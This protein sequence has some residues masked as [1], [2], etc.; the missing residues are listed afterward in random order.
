M[1]KIDIAKTDT[2]KTDTVKTDIVTRERVGLRWT[3][4]E[5]VRSRETRDEEVTR[6]EEGGGL[7]LARMARISGD[8][9]LFNIDRRLQCR[10]KEKNRTSEREQYGEPPRWRGLCTEKHQKKH[11]Q[12]TSNKSHAKVSD[13]SF[14]GYSAMAR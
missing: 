12:I 6:D 10:R 9:F 7:T 2:V 8:G 13:E 5:G 3:R 11:K 14:S 4:R 1:V